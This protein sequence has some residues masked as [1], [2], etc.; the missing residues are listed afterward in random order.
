MDKVYLVM[1]YVDYDGNDVLYITL[2]IDKAVLFVKECIDTSD[3]FT[4][5][6]T[7]QT[8]DQIY[9]STRTLNDINGN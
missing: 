4:N 6:Y 7:K 1:G 5:K 8:Y 2:N 3:R 9:I